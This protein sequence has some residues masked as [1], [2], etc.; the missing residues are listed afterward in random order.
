M[1]I[2]VRLL[3]LVLLP[4]LVPLVAGAQGRAGGLPLGP[5]KPSDM[6]VLTLTANALQA[7]A[8]LT[9]RVLPDGTATSFAVPTGRV[10][11]LQTFNFATAVTATDNLF[12][13]VRPEAG[14]GATVLFV[15]LDA[16]GPSYAGGSVPVPGVVVRAGSALCLGRNI[17]A[18]TFAQVHGFLA[19]D[20]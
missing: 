9:T 5:P 15:P 2:R 18:F 17:A 20:E 12:L 6:V 10:L 1:P 13:I 8:D 16:G 4:L 11:I 7:C 19:D 14:L 3:V